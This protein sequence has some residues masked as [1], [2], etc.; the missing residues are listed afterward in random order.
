LYRASKSS[1]DVS[2]FGRIERLLA[3]DAADVIDDLVLEDTYE[4]G[5]H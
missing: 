4:P 3:A 2:A 1:R 5:A